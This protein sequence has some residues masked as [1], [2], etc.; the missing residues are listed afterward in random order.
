MNGSVAKF[1]ITLR[2]SKKS[3]NRNLD[4]KVFIFL[5]PFIFLEIEVRS[6]LCNRS[7]VSDLIKLKSV[8]RESICTSIKLKF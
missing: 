4:L 8:W 3:K 7:N 1:E 2:I 5:K 6:K